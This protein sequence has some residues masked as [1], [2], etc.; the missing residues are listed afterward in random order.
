MRRTFTDHR[1][2]SA[3][4]FF[5][6]LLTLL[7]LFPA[8]SNAQVS[9]AVTGTHV[10]CFGASDGTATAV[11]SG[12]WAPYTYL[13]S[14]GATTATITGLA[15]GTYSVTATDIDLGYAVGSITI[16]QP[17]DLYVN[18][19][20]ESQICALAPDGWAKVVPANGTPPYTYL[21]SNGATTPL[22]T[23][24]AAGIYSV[25]VTDANGCT[26]SDS[27]EV[28]FWNEGIW[29]MDSTVDVTCF[30]LNNGFSHIGPMSG[31]PPYTFIW[32][33]GATTQDVY[34]LAPGNY[35]VT[36]TDAIGCTNF[37]NVTVTE[38]AQLMC[39][40]STVPGA[41]GLPG[42]ASVN[43]TGGTPP[44]TVLWSNGSTNFTITAMPGTY[45]VT[46]TDANDC[47][48]TASVTITST[49]NSLNVTT[50]VNS[51]AGCT[52]GGS[53]TAT[54]SG[55]TGNY[56]YSWDNGQ[57]SATATNLTA[58]NHSVT[59]VDIT[60][61]CSGMATVNIP[62][63][64]PLT[65]SAT[66]VANAT[67]LTGGSA[68]A[69]GN[70]GTPPYAFNWDNGQ[71]TATATNL[72]AGPHSV[73]VTDSK[74]CVATATITIGQ[75]QG[76]T[77]TAAVNSNA[78]CTTGGSATATA[79]GGISPYVYLW[80]NGQTTA[81]ATNLS[82]G[83][84][85]VTVTDAGG[86]SASA[87][88]TITQPDAPTVAVSSTTNASCTA[89]GSATVA[90][91]GG[92]PPYT[93]NW[94]NG[95]MTATATNLAAGTYTVT[96]TDAAGCTA[97]G[98][99]NIAGAIPPNV[100]ISAS[101]NAKCDQ[102]GSATASAT[103]GAGAYTYLWDNNETS[104]TAT[105]LAAGPHSVTVT[106]AAG[107]TATASV[108]IGFTNNGIKIGDY[109]WYDDDQDGF[110]HP[111]ETNGVPNMTVKLMKAGPDGNFNT[112]DDVVEQTT[113]TNAS[114][115]YEFT[116]VTPG[117]YVIH[118]SGIPAGY[119]FTK[120]DYVANDCKDSDANAQGK[121]ASFTIVAGQTDNLCF[122][123][124]IHIFCDNVLNA[125]TICCNQTI[126]EGETPMLIY[127]VQ[128]PWGGTGAIEYQWLQLLQVGQ[129]PPNWVAIP[130]ATSATYQPGPLFETA[131]YMRCA[132]RA[133]CTTFLESNIVT[134]TVQPAGSAN[135]PDF[136]G[137]I[138][139]SLVGQNT[140]LVEWTT[141]QPETDQYLYTVQHSTNSIDWVP[142]TT[143]M[144]HRDAT[145]PNHYSI[146]HQTP[147]VGANYYRVKR[148]N[149]GGLESVSPVRSIDLALSPDAAIAINPNPVY[150]V[151]IIKT[152]AEYDG[153]VTVQLVTTNGAVLHTLTIPAGKLYYEELSVKD[154][155]SGLYMARI[156]FPDGEVRTLKIAK[157]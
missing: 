28:V 25:T 5:G 72:G 67:C 34:N 69:A 153:D 13:W 126:C 42:S 128:S 36:V 157:F 23:G 132:R 8:F 21:W 41:C 106:D 79:S 111:L 24:L 143:V 105:N 99:V 134:I 3:P 65:A 135:C 10:T 142:V 151:L 149:A 103:G 145:K 104:A 107:C 86:C 66:L 100:V 50:T 146:V 114:G 148:T 70:G 141:A 122:D 97:T 59:V 109:V 75:N 93:Y 147:V 150:D 53:A 60:T 117:T 113:T 37:H 127:N 139:A 11:A 39:N 131:Y 82:V 78:T 138:S 61:G 73:T 27:C 7:L 38:P 95:A 91:S 1:A 119:E 144:G 56:S 22:I 83:P 125:G 123:A 33:N 94:S 137:D 89:G 101:S 68:T 140:V 15:P 133:G 29:L 35:T 108:T 77:V 124:G 84:H 63:A 118:F 4:F 32:S 26:K 130:G 64:P 102:P 80:D 44:Y 48:C 46:V 58:G 85:M 136:T 71:T 120:K 51:S 9:V 112:P 76:P 14:N 87:S 90:A 49:T 43:P 115:K 121:T 154:L 74:G 12:G 81:T 110:Q 156:R 20:C 92:T 16:T 19:S 96:A 55:G 17:T 62:S 30:G 18:V 129:G 155:P 57:M 88:V 47:T 152:V 54:A 116:C 6:G 31:T 52:V 40:A 98:T 2:G 45:G